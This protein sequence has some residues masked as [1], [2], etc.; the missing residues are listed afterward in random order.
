MFRGGFQGHDALH[1][2]VS[3]LANYPFVQR[4]THI[5]MV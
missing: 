4:L 3:K 5:N 2:L 1:T